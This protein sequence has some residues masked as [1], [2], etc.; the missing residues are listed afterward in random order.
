[1]GLSL[2]RI[3]WVRV[4]IEV[5]LRVVGV[6]ELLFQRVE[7]SRI[8]AGA[9]FGFGQVRREGC[10]HLERGRL[11]LL[12]L[13]FSRLFRE[14]RAL[15]AGVNRGVVLLVLCMLLMLLLLLRLMMMMKMMMRGERFLLLDQNN[16]LSY[17]CD[18]PDDL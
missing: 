4:G 2:E 15:N 5:A 10:V 14:R 13:A 6:G 8:R 16:I 7:L 11:L 17:R 1:M 9:H 3:R 12:L 18:R